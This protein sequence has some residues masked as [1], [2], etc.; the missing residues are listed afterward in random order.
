M[1]RAA[2]SFTQSAAAMA[3]LVALCTL[4]WRAL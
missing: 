4:M 1:I 2:I 3:G